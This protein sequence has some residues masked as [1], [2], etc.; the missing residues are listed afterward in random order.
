MVCHAFGLGHAACTMPNA[1]ASVTSVRTSLF[2]SVSSSKDS[3]AFRVLPM[4]TSSMA[5]S[6]SANPVRTLIRVV[7]PPA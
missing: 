6:W 2:G 3:C 7:F 1:K 4:S 5:W